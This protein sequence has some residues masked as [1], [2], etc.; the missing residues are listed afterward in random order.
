MDVIVCIDDNGGML[1]GGRRQSRDRVVNED[2]LSAGGTLWIAPMSATLFP[3]A[4]VSEHFLDEAG[5]EERCFAEDRALMP[6]LA[7]IERLILYR[8]NRV[9][10]YDFCLDIDP[11]AVG[12]RLAEQTELVGHSHPSIIKEVWQR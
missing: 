1:F 3:D 12:M 9:Y 4:R 10:P 2:I 11:A 8:W 5:A 6:Y 7:R